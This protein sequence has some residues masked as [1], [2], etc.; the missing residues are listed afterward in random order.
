[1]I[2]NDII[3]IC[4]KYNE[5]KMD[6]E[7]YLRKKNKIDAFSHVEYFDFEEK[8]NDFY[9]EVFNGFDDRGNVFYI[10]IEK[11]L[12]WKNGIE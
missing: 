5:L 1:M 2:Y 7:E 11:F 3:N 10:D 12:D 4:S 8:H 9:I 6:L